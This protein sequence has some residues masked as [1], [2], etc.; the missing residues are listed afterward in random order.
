MCKVIDSAMMAQFELHQEALVRQ[1]SVT[2]ALEVHLEDKVCAERRMPIGQ[3]C[4]QLHG[5]GKGDKRKFDEH[6]KSSFESD[7]CA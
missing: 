2:A 6:I 3:S 4:R 1:Q 5:K 7:R